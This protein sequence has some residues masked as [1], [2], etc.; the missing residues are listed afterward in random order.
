MVPFQWKDV[1]L[2]LK[3]ALCTIVPSLS[4]GGSLVNVEAQAASCPVVASRVGGIPE[5]VQDEISGLLFEAGNPKD[6]AK[7]IIKI[8]SDI[9]LR[10]K[11]I[12]G[13][14]EH[15]KKFSWDVLGPQYLALYDEMIKMK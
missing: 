5:Y 8:L 13:G 9:P 15:A 2:F 10:N 4:E 3:G 12:Q 7:K 14:I 6:L 1:S 11:L